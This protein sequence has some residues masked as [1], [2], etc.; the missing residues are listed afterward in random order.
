ML[1]RFILVAIAALSI[2]AVACSGGGGSGADIEPA[3]SY[4]SLSA[5]LEAGGM[6]IGGRVDNNPLFSRLFSVQG[7]E[8]NASGQEIL[9]FEFETIEEAEEQAALVSEDGFGIGLKYVNWIAEPM[10]YK[11][12]KMIVVYDGSQSLV[13]DTLE[14]AMGDIFA[15]GSI[16]G[17]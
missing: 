17:A 11:N 15:G 10:F 14:A 9:A 8:L 4:D 7:I 1:R 16:D 12:G 2:I 3:D 13:I 6:T 5:A